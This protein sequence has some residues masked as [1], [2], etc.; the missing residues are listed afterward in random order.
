M[1]NSRQLKK[2][3]SATQPEVIEV[4]NPLGHCQFSTLYRTTAAYIGW[5]ARKT[6]P[7]AKETVSTTRHIFLLSLQ[8]PVSTCMY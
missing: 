6:P 5:E 3:Y 8:V 1:E 2:S 4:E 7:A